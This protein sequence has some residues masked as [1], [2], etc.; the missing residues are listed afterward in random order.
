MRKKDSTIKHLRKLTLSKMVKE[1]GATKVANVRFWLFAI[2]FIIGCIALFVILISPMK[3]SLLQYYWWLFGTAATLFSLS[4]GFLACASKKGHADWWYLKTK[5]GRILDLDEYKQKEIKTYFI[6]KKYITEGKSNKDFYLA[7]KDSIKDNIKPARKINASR[8]LA[9]IP[10]I[11]SI[12]TPLI[13]ATSNLENKIYIS[14][15]ISLAYF[16]LIVLY[17]LLIN[18]PKN[19]TERYYKELNSILDELL[20]Q[21]AIDCN[22]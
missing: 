13:N 15:M 3:P 22:R 20:V 5:E 8:Q 6:K 16:I 17:Q 14:Y 7:L 2:L 11:L 12:I 9:I 21:D 19:K 18:N 1:T 10:I 4:I